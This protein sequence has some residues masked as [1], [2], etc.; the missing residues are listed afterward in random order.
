M[1]EPCPAGNGPGWYCSPSGSPLSVAVHCAPAATAA[2]AVGSLDW[3]RCSESAAPGVMVIGCRGGA[4]SSGALTELLKNHREE[5]RCT[6]WV[7]FDSSSTYRSGINAARAAICTSPLAL[8]SARSGRKP[9]SILTDSPERGVWRAITRPWS[10]AERP[11]LSGTVRV[12]GPLRIQRRLLVWARRRS[13]LSEI[14]R[15]A[16]Q[17]F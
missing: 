4:A 16:G 14:V 9:N 12:T 5:P 3:P 17:R 2:M 13:V 1:I 15:G 10:V 6:T 11:S 8:L 7:I